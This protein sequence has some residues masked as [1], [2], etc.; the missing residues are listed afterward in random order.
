MLLELK[1]FPK[2]L[3]LGLLLGS[4]DKY[5]PVAPLEEELLDGPLDSRSVVPQNPV[6]PISCVLFRLIEPIMD[7]D[8][9]LGLPAPFVYR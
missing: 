9:V 5:E 4:C 6:G 3:V 8:V 7:F 1:L 2:I